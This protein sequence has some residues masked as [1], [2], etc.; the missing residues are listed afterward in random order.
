M[1]K[2]LELRSHRSL[3]FTAALVAALVLSSFVGIHTVYAD[4]GFNPDQAE[5]GGKI[6]ERLE[7][8]YDKLN[9][10]YEI[11]DTNLGKAHNALQRVEE[12]LAKAGALGIDTSAIEA[13]LPELYAANDQAE[14]SHA[15]ADQIL[16]EH[17][18]FNGGGKVKDRQ[19]A[20]ETCK[21]GRDALAS[22]R[23]SLITA[24]EIVREIIGLV[25]ELRESYVPT[26]DVR[27]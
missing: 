23:E 18:G 25:R 17:A 22:A 15:L 13:L 8:C 5:R 7:A 27:S 2:Q 26:V 20:L 21:S 19:Q 11:Q 14:A 9:D 16:S 12:A 6:D 1:K 24:R 3:I 4:E 10:W